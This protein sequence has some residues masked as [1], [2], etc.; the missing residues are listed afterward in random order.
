MFLYCCLHGFLSIMLYFCMNACYRFRNR[1]VYKSMPIRLKP[2]HK[3]PLPLPPGMTVK[4]SILDSVTFSFSKQCSLA[5][6]QKLTPTIQTP[7]VNAT[8]SSEYSS[9]S[10]HSFRGSDNSVY[11]TPPAPKNFM[12]SSLHSEDLSFSLFAGNPDVD[13]ISLSSTASSASRDR[14][15]DGGS[16][17]L[18]LPMNR[19]SH[20]PSS[21][22][23]VSVSNFCTRINLKSE[24]Y[25]SRLLIIRSIEGLAG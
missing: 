19:T 13:Q 17:P 14:R 10:S 7:V 20:S 2:K 16:T 1:R 18:Y 8:S 11:Q 25:C 22:S 3:R 6:L 12:D 9:A 23:K 15:T 21:N 5:N 24:I 4:D